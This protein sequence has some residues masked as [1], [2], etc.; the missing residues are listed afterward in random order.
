MK[1]LAPKNMFFAAENMFVWDS[2]STRRG[3][4]SPAHAH[5]SAQTNSC[6]KSCLGAGREQ[7][8]GALHGKLQA[9]LWWERRV[10][11]GAARTED[12]RRNLP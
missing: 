12:Q 2:G 6:R 4:H 1:E 8:R 11:G 5:E 7:G 10:T 9:V 3:H